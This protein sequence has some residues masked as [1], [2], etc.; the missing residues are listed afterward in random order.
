MRFL[1]HNHGDVCTLYV[2]VVLEVGTRR[3]VHWTVT[4][5][6]TAEWTIQ[7]FPAI[8]PAFNR[9][10]GIASRISL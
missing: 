7:Q 2:F 9:I 8:V 5:H 10:G 3:I 6:P 1:R 4:E